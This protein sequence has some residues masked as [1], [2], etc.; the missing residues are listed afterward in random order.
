M[1]ESYVTQN[2]ITRGETALGDYLRSSQTDFGNVWREAFSDL[3]TD[4]INRNVEIRRLCKRFYLESTALTKTAPYDGVISDEDFGQRLRLVIP[5]TAIT[6]TGVFTLQGTDDEG[7]NYFD[8]SMVSDSGASSVTM[9][10]TED[11]TYS[12]SST[13]LF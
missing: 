10:V 13:A 2:M 7:V 3:M 1:I 12:F 5:I 6:G 8:I 9:S 11:S 4:L